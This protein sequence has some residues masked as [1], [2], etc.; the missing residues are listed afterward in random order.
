MN[1]SVYWIHSKDHSDMFSEGYIGVSNNANHRWSYGHKWAVKNNRHENPRFMNAINKHGWDNLIK[2]VI[3]IADSDYCYA[4]EKKL[5]PSE[6]IGWNIAIGGGKPP[7]TKSRGDDYVSPLKGV[8][9]HTPW[10]IGRVPSNKGIKASEET[11]AKLSLVKKGKKQTP[12]QVAKRVASR[13][14]TLL[15]QGRTV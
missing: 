7:I 14:A 13:R 5:R 10:M 15:S 4:V 9:R 11:R 12:E 8:T 3:L 1:T 2:E 6:K